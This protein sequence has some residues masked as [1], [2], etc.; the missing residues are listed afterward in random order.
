[1][2]TKKRNGYRLRSKLCFDKYLRLALKVGWVGTEITNSYLHFMMEWGS[3]NK[4]LE[5][6][7]NKS[8]ASFIYVLTFSIESEEKIY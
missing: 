7:K 8:Q 6:V 3:E 2:E 1:M 4:K 5:W